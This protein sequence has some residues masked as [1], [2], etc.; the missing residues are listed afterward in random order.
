VVK[1]EE[2]RTTIH[3]AEE[4]GRVPRRAFEYLQ[5]RAAA[6]AAAMLLFVCSATAQG[7]PPVPFG[8]AAPAFLAEISGTEA[9]LGALA[10]VV[11]LVGYHFT[12]GRYIREQAGVKDV[13]D[14]RLVEQPIEYRKAARYATHEELAGVKSDVERL[15]LELSADVTGLQSKIDERFE[16][17]NHERRVSIANL[18]TKIDEHEQRD[19]DRCMMIME[20]IGTLTGGQRGK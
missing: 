10:L 9:G 20:K 19:A 13:Q 11:T 14:T 7:E 17:L 1:I 8:G 4:H 6:A 2:T 15:R 12:I 16:Q 18:H 3:L 5:R